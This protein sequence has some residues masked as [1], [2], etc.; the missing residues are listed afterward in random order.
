M[1]RLPR[2]AETRTFPARDKRAPTGG[3][4]M[5]RRSPDGVA[6]CLL[7]AL[8]RILQSRFRYFW[9]D[10]G[11]LSGFAGQARRSNALDV[12]N[13]RRVTSA[14]SPYGGEPAYSNRLEEVAL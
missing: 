8:L 3:C 4:C 12:D 7:P 13:R 10:C 11:I 14:I 1:P 6:F 5:T 2:L 9:L